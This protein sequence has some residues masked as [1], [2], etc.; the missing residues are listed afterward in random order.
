MLVIFSGMPG[1]GKTTLAE[2]AA[3]RLRAPVFAIDVVEAALWR[4]G[5]VSDMGS[6][7]AAYELL[8]TLADGQLRRRQS[9]CID[10]VVGLQ[11]ARESWAALAR[12]Y[13]ATIRFVECICSDRELHR[14]RVK[15]RERNIP[16]WYELSWADVERSMKSFEPWH[17][18]RLTLDAA[19]SLEANLAELD[20]YLF[21]ERR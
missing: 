13:D 17:G 7:A 21:G 8:S 14:Q 19:R 16:G 4:S 9:A 11:S 15:G 2:H 1:T 20:G 6:H 3:R 12:R 10:A 5:V 18:E